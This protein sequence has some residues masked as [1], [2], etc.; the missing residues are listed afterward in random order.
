MTAVERAYPHREGDVVALLFGIE[1]ERFG[2]D[3]TSSEP[4]G[5]DQLAGRLGELGDCPG[6]AI[7][8]EDMAGRADTVGDFACGGARSAADLDH[9]ETG[10]EGQGIDDR[11]EPGRQRSHPPHGRARSRSSSTGETTP[12][13]ERL[14]TT[15]SLVLRGRC[16]S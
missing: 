15:G 2:R 10:A 8:C 4:S 3:L 1:P 7:D 11:S 5:R 9:P 12:N 16:G 13:R 14:A 6:G